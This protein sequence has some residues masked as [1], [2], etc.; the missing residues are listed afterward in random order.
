MRNLT[1]RTRLALTFGGLTLIVLLVA[2]ISISLLSNANARFER[3]VGGINARAAMA[4]RVR[5]AI[6]LRAIAARNLVLVSQ[7][8]DRELE[9]QTVVKAHADATDSLAKLQELAN[10]ADLPEQVRQMIAEI[11]KVEKAYAPVALAIVDLALKGQHDAAIQKMNDE[12]RPLFAALIKATDAYADFTAARAQ[13]QIQAAEE[14]YTLQR[15]ALLGT[16][17]VAV[18][19]AV[20]AGV[21]IT[22]GLWHELGAEPAELRGIMG[23]VAGGDL[24]AQIHLRPGDENSVLAKVQSMQTSLMQIVTAV[25]QDADSVSSAAAQ[26]ASSNQDL[27]SRTES[28]ASALE[29]SASSMEEFSAT[30]QQNADNARQANQLAQS[31]SSVAA[32]GGDVV[33]KVVDTMQGI[34]D[35][36][37]RIADI[38]SV[39]DGIAF[40]T[41]ILALN[42]AV[43]AARAGEQGRGFAVVASEVRSLAGRSA[44]AAREIKTL[45]S[46]SVERVG[47]GAALVDDA[48]KTMA[49]IVSGIRQVASIIGDISTASQEQSRGV[50]QVG[51]AVSHMDRATQQNAAMVEE[52]AAA[53]TEMSA[54]AQQLVQ[55]VSV[56]KVARQ[57]L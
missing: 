42:A 36:S 53:A 26:I 47:Q 16:G 55:A 51:E 24:T 6:D 1:V 4:A 7:D 10:A 13:T 35:S 12:C 28:Q 17:V 48:G 43:E 44:E 22:R 18:L 50:L 41:N 21:T 20:T 23:R 31:A 37:R 39:I 25:R 56:F 2:G 33:G 15:N 49:D 29:Q 14:D 5:A 34:N 30:V 54:K 32:H 40:Q 19:L 38:I 9:R 27:S 11:A 46:A 8:A 57:A 45:I 52:M 3:Y